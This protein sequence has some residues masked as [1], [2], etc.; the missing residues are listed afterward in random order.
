MLRDILYAFY[1]YRTAKYRYDVAIFFVEFFDQT[2][3]IFVHNYTSLVK[4]PTK[5]GINKAADLGQVAGNETDNANDTN[6]EQSIHVEKPPKFTCGLDSVYG[7]DSPA[8][9]DQTDYGY[10]I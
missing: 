7:T 9:T 4:V 6:G 5:Q 3:S 2:R 10:L 1:P 8:E